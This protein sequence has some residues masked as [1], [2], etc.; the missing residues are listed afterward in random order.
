SISK[1]S[2]KLIAENFSGNNRRTYFQLFII[3]FMM[4]QITTK[5]RWRKRVAE[6]IHTLSDD[7]VEK[8]MG[9]PKNSIF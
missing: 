1:E 9:F 5:S 7:F 3:D 2:T 8:H 6:H 4:R